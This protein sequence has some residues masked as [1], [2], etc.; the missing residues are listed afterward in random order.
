MSLAST[1]TITA[2]AATLLASPGANAARRGNTVLTRA[3]EKPII[4]VAAALRMGVEVGSGGAFLS[5]PLGFGFGL[6][7]R[8]HALPVGPMRFGFELQAGHTRFPSIRSYPR[9]GESGA[10][11]SV[12]RTTLLAHTDITLGPSFQAPLGRRVFLEFGGGGGLIVSSFNRPRSA[13]PNED[14]QLVGYSPAVRGDIGFGI[15]IVRNQGLRLG[16]SFQKMFSNE[17]VVS[18]L[19]APPGAEPDSIVFDMYLD[20]SLAYQAWF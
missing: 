5:P 16:A 4:G 6:D 3:P 8:Y 20:I 13:D 10:L 7:L 9:M 18:D 12:P 1:L 2:Y 11:E 17:Q 19:D 14:Q 15:P